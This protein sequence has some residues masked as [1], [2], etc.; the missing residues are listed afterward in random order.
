MEPGDSVPHS[1]VLSNI[2]IYPIPRID[3]YLF[4][5]H[6]NIFLS[7]TP[8]RSWRSLFCSLLVKNSKELL[9]S[10]ILG[11][12]PAYLNL[13]HLVTL[14]ILCERFKLRSSSLWS[15]SHSPFTPILG[16]NIRLRVL[17]SNTLYSAFLP[18][19]RGH[20]LQECT[21]TDNVI[22]FIF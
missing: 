14:T 8:R 2:P 16:S 15:L 10:S 13:L 20:V 21:T 17:F 12:W 19:V 1:K 9:T 4:K 11:T 6:S 22:V 3:T 7:S 18:N 5:V